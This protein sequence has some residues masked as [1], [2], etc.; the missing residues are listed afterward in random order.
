MVDRPGLP[1]Y[2][3]AMGSAPDEKLI[4][5]LLG[6]I[7][8]I[9]AEEQVQ[10]PPG[11]QQTILGALLLEANRVVSMDQLIDLVW[12]HTPPSTARAQIQICV[13]AL[14]REFTRVPTCRAPVS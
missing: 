1:K 14:R 12:A 9:G 10:V 5:K 2:D 7:E 13:S 4:F 11:R 3:S 8:V 6:P